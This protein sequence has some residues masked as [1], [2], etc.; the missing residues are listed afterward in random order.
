MK[1]P[2][3]FC[4]LAGGLCLPAPILADQHELQWH[5]RPLVG[6]AL[7]RDEW[8]S[9]LGAAPAAGASLGIS[10]GVTNHL[11]LG[12]EALSF[13]T[14]AGTFD[15]AAVPTNG[16]TATGPYE[17]RARFHGGT[18]NATWRLG[19]IWVPVINVGVGR[20]V[21]YRSAG[22]FS[23]FD[24]APMETPAED[25][26]DWLVTTRSGV[27]YRMT[28]RWTLG[29]YGSLLMAYSPDAPGLAAASLSFGVSYVHYP[30]W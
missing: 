12:L 4:V 9:D 26:K 10:Y 11:D 5:A 14:L 2:L 21:R 27:E 16:Y 7:M 23:E 6:V 30:N 24:F 13:A 29:A 20:T 28:P 25:V 8:A 17:R 22:V 19:V 1:H 15:E 18:V 3:L